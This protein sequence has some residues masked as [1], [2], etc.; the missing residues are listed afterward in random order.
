MKTT[1]IV[2]AI[3]KEPPMKLIIDGSTKIITL[4]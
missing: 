4:M 1:D 2:C 3:K